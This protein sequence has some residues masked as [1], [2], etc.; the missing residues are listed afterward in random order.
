MMR[1]IA[2]KVAILGDMRVGKTSLMNRFIS[3]TFEESY[4]STLGINISKKK[5]NYSISGEDFVLTLYVWDVMG[6]SNFQEVR[7][8]AFENVDGAMIVGDLTNSAS[9]KSITDFWLPSITESSGNKEIALILNKL[10]LLGDALGLYTEFISSIRTE[11]GELADEWVAMATSAKSGEN[12]ERAFYDIARKIL[13]SSVAP[14]N[15]STAPEGVQDYGSIGGAIR[16][17]SSDLEFL[18][19]R[20]DNAVIEESL[21]ASTLDVRNPLR[22]EFDEFLKILA[23]HLESMGI[24]EQKA[25]G[26][27]EK[28]SRLLLAT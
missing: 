11:W 16:K 8:L 2:K 26:Y 13:V 14:G 4:S 24:E 23:N 21:K 1:Q 17:I 10:D 19:G 27:L 5:L 7:R 20:R 25:N 28:W 9:L 12:V 3:N 22:E 6:G 15:D 18:L